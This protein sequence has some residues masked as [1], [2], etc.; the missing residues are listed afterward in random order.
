MVWSE[1]MSFQPATEDVNSFRRPAV[2]L[3]TCYWT[4]CVDERERGSVRTQN[5]GTQKLS[6]ILKLLFSSVPYQSSEQHCRLESVT[7]RQI[8]FI[9]VRLLHEF[10]SSMCCVIKQWGDSYLALTCIISSDLAL[11]RLNRHLEWPLV[12]RS[13]FSVLC[14]WT[15]AS[16]G[17]SVF[18]NT[19]RTKEIA[20][21]HMPNLQ[22]GPKNS[23]FVIGRI[24]Q[25]LNSSLLRKNSKIQA[26][27]LRKSGEF[28]LSFNLLAQI[29]VCSY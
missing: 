8:H 10:V 6:L 19:E 25:H 15:C 17:H 5:R 13:Y 28:C 22:L 3:I 12:I 20:I 18:L 24:S 7:N 9:Y 27:F 14:K 2:K 11:R 16:L 1:Q 21:C 4:A 29:V 23:E 26:I